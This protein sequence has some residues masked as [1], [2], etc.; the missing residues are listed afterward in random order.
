VPE[1]HGVGQLLH[2]LKSHSPQSPPAMLG[3]DVEF[4][5][6]RLAS[7]KFQIKTEG[8]HDV[9]DCSLSTL[10]E[11]RAAQLRPFQERL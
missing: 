3:P 6:G 4:S 1:R 11:P 8:H 10:N 2:V 5:D 9:T 7:A